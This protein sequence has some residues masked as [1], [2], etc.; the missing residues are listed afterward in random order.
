M[1]RLGELHMLFMLWNVH[2]FGHPKHHWTL[3]WKGL[4]L[5]SRNR[6]LKT[7][8]F[9]GS[10]YLGHKKLYIYLTL[11]HKILPTK[12][13]RSEK[14]HVKMRKLRAN[15]PYFCWLVQKERKWSTCFFP[16]KNTK[17]VQVFE[18]WWVFFV[19]RK[20][21]GLSVS[22]FLHQ[23]KQKPLNWPLIGG[24][25]R[26]LGSNDRELQWNFC[27][28]FWCFWLKNGHGMNQDIWPGEMTCLQEWRWQKLCRCRS[29]EVVVVEMLVPT[30]FLTATTL[31]ELLSGV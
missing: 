16:N 13:K 27:V 18:F 12:P 26:P 22:K 11:A 28:A 17:N 7:A 19:G 20:I 9:E 8:S 24:F 29:V 14:R 23:A 1:K 5:Y 3:Q 31:A 15:C 4:N 25:V 6:V 10:G 2:V 21:Q 30:S